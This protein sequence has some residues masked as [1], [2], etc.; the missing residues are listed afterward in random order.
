MKGFVSWL[1]LASACGARS[2]LTQGDGGSSPIG[3]GG[4]GAGPTGG[5]TA[6][7]GAAPLC[8]GFV[9][10]GEP[11]AIPFGQNATQ[12]DVGQTADGRT[13]VAWRAQDGTLVGD[14]SL[15]SRGPWPD[16]FDDVVTLAPSAS[17]FVA[18]PGQIGPMALLEDQE[19]GG[20]L[21][22]DL[23]GVAPPIVTF[24][25]AGEPMFVAQSSERTLFASHQFGFL[26]V[27]SWS[28]R[29]GVAL[30]GPSICLGTTMLGGAIAKA[31]GF[32]TAYADSVAPGQSCF[33]QVPQP[34][35]NLVTM[36]YAPGAPMPV[37]LVE[38]L[39][40]N[41]P[42]LHLALVSTGFGA[43]LVYQT[44]GST[45][46]TMPAIAAYRVDHG[47]ALQPEEPGPIPLTPDGIST[48]QLAASAMD[49]ALVIAWVDSVD[50]SA[51]MVIVQ[52]IE[53]D[54]SLGPAASFGTH[55]AWLSGRLR[56]TTTADQRSL[57]LAWTADVDKSV[58]VARISCAAR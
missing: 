1:L 42:L 41:E 50:P 8:E 35:L 3:A 4:S 31:D 44:D 5:G 30:E 6:S 28:E 27:G 32:V 11:F 37:T 43:W 14:P 55:A 9:V 13:F 47:G 33:A 51:P 36:R 26:T 15:G 48:S 2:D 53:A 17:S 34:G 57:I 18:G 10:D 58:G 40:Q 22:R 54:G 16:P 52:R 46:R 38:Q 49:D 56:M 25:G 23:F 39:P 29:E 12:P 21:E 19:G 7:G 24:S 20:S 45:S